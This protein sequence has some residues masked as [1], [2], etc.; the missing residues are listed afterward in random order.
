MVE[1]DM[2]RARAT[3]ADITRVVRAA[4]KAGI[5]ARAKPRRLPKHVTVE[6][7]RH[8][9]VVFYFRRPR[10][11]RV[12]LPGDPESQEF[13]DAVAAASAGLSPPVI[14]DEKKPG[15]PRGRVSL[16]YFIG[17]LNHMVKIGH[18]KN[19]RARM[20]EIQVGCHWNLKILKTIRG[21]L[22]EER[23][24][25]KAFASSHV[26]REWFYATGALEKFI[27]SGDL[28]Y[29]LESDEVVDADL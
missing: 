3:Q 22:A 1:K 15:A 11:E 13:R 6:R 4:G 14:E 18:S 5:P 24:M 2:N 10:G 20:R 8:G 9:K 29:A 23:Q 16:V 12:R 26:R 19:V 25:H 28:A 27:R 7:S 21:G 17:D